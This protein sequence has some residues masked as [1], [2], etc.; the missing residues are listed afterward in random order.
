MVLNAIDAAVTGAR[1]MPSEASEE[2]DYLDYED[3]ESILEAF[4]EERGEYGLN[5]NR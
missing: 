1:D 5:L 2:W 4:E 3:Y